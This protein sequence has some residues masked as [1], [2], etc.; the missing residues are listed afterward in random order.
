M[1]ITLSTVAQ[2]KLVATNASG[3]TGITL[4]TGSKRD[5]RGLIKLAAKSILQEEAEKAATTI[6]EIEV[7]VLPV[8]LAKDTLL[9]KLQGKGWT[10][11]AALTDDKMFWLSKDGMSVLGY[12][13]ID[14]DAGNAYF[15]KSSTEPQLSPSVPAVTNAEVP[16]PVSPPVIPNP[17]G[18]P[19]VGATQNPPSG[20]ILGT[21]YTSSLISNNITHAYTKNQYTFRSD[22]TYA[23]YKKTFD[24]SWS[25]ML[26]RREQGTYTI[27][28]DQL[29]LKP[30]RCVI[31]KWNKK[32]RAD[33]WGELLS[34]DQRPLEPTTYHFSKHYFEG[35]QEWNLVLTPD[36]QTE[37][38]G[39]FANNSSFPNSYLYTIPPS[40]D[41]LITLP[42]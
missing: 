27:Q 9:K 17:S 36:K 8:T 23:F 15:G 21:W 33:Q 12:F 6:G 13:S 40:D 24:I 11:R 41:Y 29:I 37:R 38:D 3:I 35:I 19:I 5:D 10:V 22:G 7:L 25:F 28:G 31:E 42:N 1:A 34:T 2:K 18:A 4:P 20:E 39:K 14:A 30:S 26:L 32:D 16:A